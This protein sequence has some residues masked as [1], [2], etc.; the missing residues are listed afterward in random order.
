MSRIRLLGATFRPFRVNEA[1]NLTPVL[2]LVRPSLHTGLNSRMNN[3]MVR[4][5]QFWKLLKINW[6]WLKAT[7]FSTL[8]TMFIHC[9]S[10]S[11]N[12]SKS[13]KAMFMLEIFTRVVRVNGKQPIF[14]HALRTPWGRLLGTS[15][16]NDADDNANVKKIIGLIS[17]TT[18]SHAHHTFLYI[19]FPFFHD[20]DVKMPNFAFYRGRKQATT[21][22]YFSFRAWVWSLEIQRQEGSP[23]FDKVS[24]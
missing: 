2:F 20:Y 7:Q 24:G 15:R 22:Y 9:A 5:I 18:T 10:C 1:W 17:K 12:T 16:S 19:S 3:Q 13:Y 23:T 4:A 11:P 14:L 8:F 21:K 6:L